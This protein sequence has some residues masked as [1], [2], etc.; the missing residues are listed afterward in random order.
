MSEHYL[1]KRVTAPANLPVTVDQ[2]KLDLRLQYDAEDSIITSIIQ[3]ATDYVDV[4][5]GVIN[6]A[7][8]TQNWKLSAR[9]FDNGRIDIPVSP[10][11]SIESIQYFDINEEVQTIDADN[12][13]L[14]GDEDSA[15]LQA[16]TAFAMPAFFDRLDAVNI[17]FIAGFG[18]TAEDI[19]ASI[20]QALRMLCAFWFENRTAVAVGAGLVVTEL[21]L[22]VQSLI[23]INRKGWVG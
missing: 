5:R 4:P 11:Q 23:S 14:Y 12:F 22:A 16:K 13:Y 10:V 21:P 7:L 1:L 9:G 18:D 19:P 6:K 3:A 15:W 20:S 2:V 17:T 8:I